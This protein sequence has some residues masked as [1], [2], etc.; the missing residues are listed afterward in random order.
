MR[1]WEWP[2]NKRPAGWQGAFG[3]VDGIRDAS[4]AVAVRAGPTGHPVAAADPRDHPAV[5]VDHPIPV[6]AAGPRASHGSCSSPSCSPNP[7]P[8]TRRGTIAGRDPAA[9]AP[10]L[11]CPSPPIPVRRLRPLLR[12]NV[13]ASSQRCR[14]PVGNAG[15]TSTPDAH[16]AAPCRTTSAGCGAC[17]CEWISDAIPDRRDRPGRLALGTVPGVG[18]GPVHANCRGSAPRPSCRPSRDP[19]SRRG[20]IAETDPA[21][22]GLRLLAR[23]RPPQDQ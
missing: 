6:V 9:L 7:G 5:A 11:R 3:R 4:R 13:E 23:L 14:Y 1:R 10:E 17:R 18:W 21:A 16:R 2:P 12:L 19:R 15:Q 8:R 22:P 20:T